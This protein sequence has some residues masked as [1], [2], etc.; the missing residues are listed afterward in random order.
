[1]KKNFYF[2]NMVQ[3]VSC[4][5]FELTKFQEQIMRQYKILSWLSMW[6]KQRHSLIQAFSWF[7]GFYILVYR[8]NTDLQLFS[9]RRTLKIIKKKMPCIVFEQINISK[10]IT[11]K[12]TFVNRIHLPAAFE[13]ILIIT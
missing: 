12:D 7:L 6:Q 8:N 10:N 13:I 9:L 5:T 3:K 1:M 4:V 2:L 11:C